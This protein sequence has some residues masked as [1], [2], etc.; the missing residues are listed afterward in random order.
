MGGDGAAGRQEIGEEYFIETGLL[1]KLRAKK[2]LTSLLDLQGEDGAF[3]D[4]CFTAEG[5]MGT[6]RVKQFVQKFAVDDKCAAS[7]ERV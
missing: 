6:A 5:I 7:G 3:V 2:E 1:T 4:S